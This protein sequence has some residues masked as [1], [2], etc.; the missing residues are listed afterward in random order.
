[1]TQATVRGVQPADV[2]AIWRRVEPILSRA[3]QNHT[4]ESPG[5]VMLDILG[6]RIQLW[7][8]NDYQAVCLTQI[9]V[10][11]KAKVLWVYYVA[12]KGMADWLGELVQTLKAFAAY[13]GC[14]RLEFNGRLGWEKA[15]E[16]H[17]F[18][19]KS[20]TMRLEL[21]G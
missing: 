6:E 11:P 7:Q 17:G 19:A 5:D 14:S 20:I 9:H 16:R 8:I 13:K 2:P 15:L 21:G 18:G 3:I 1:M 10:R 4:D 12:G